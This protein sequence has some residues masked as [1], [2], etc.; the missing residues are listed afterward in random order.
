MQFDHQRSK[1][2]RSRLDPRL[3]SEKAGDSRPLRLCRF[4]QDGLVFEVV[5]FLQAGLLAFH[6]VGGFLNHSVQV[7]R[8]AGE[9]TA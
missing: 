8:V 5:V 1:H 4:L 9:E 7:F 2:E 3:A 6:P